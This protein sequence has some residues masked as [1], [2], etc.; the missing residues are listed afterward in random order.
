MICTKCNIEKELTEFPIR[1]NESKPRT[2]C[3]DCV[4][5]M[6]RVIYKEKGRVRPRT[7]KKRVAK[8]KVD[9]FNPK[10]RFTVA[11][12]KIERC[13]YILCNCIIE[14]GTDRSSRIYGTYKGKKSL[15]CSQ[16]CK[17]VALIDKKLGLNTYEIQHQH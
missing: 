8:A 5:L 2:T 4:R 10:P 9:T 15:Y 11:L 16:W 3:K 12:H 14:E 13:S 7:P 1:K 6:A 17:E